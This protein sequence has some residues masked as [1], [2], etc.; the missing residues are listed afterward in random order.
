M[1]A[2]ITI[3]EALPRWADAHYPLKSKTLLDRC[4]GIEAQ[5]QPR[6]KW[7]CENVSQNR[8]FTM[9]SRARFSTYTCWS[10]GTEN[11]SPLAWWHGCLAVYANG[12]HSLHC[13]SITTLRVYSVCRALMS[14]QQHA[15]GWRLSLTWSPLGS[16]VIPCSLWRTHLRCNQWLASCGLKL[17]SGLRCFR[18]HVPPWTASC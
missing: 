4:R 18:F 14:P 1:L 17:L 10:S 5:K 9:Y 11:S 13:S 2:R 3:A 6:P 16:S 12:W 15:G 7:S 8:N